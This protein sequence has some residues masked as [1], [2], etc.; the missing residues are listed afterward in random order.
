MRISQKKCNWPSIEI[1][2]VGG[3]GQIMLLLH[4][5]VIFEFGSKKGGALTGL[6]DCVLQ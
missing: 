6:E 5:R 1:F 4:M 3:G 2:R